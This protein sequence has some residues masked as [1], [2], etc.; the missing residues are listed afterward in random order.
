MMQLSQGRGNAARRRRS[1]AVGLM[2]VLSGGAVELSAS[3]ANAQAATETAKSD[4]AEALFEQA[5]DLV[6]SGKL[7]EACEKFAASN[8]LEPGVG[9]LLYLGDCYERTDRFASAITTFREAGRLA[10]E[11]QD[12]ERAHVAEV[13]SAALQPRAPKL[14]VRVAKKSEVPGLQV[15]LNGTPMPQE[16]WNVAHF[17]DAGAYEVRVAAPGYEPFSSRIELRNGEADLTVV[18]IPRLVETAA[19]SEAGAAA[20]AAVSIEDD[21][22]LVSQETLGLIVGGAGVLLAGTTGLLA[23]FANSSNQDSYDFCDEGDRN[24]CR[25][26]G[27]RLREEAQDFAMVATITG[28]AATAAVAGGVVLY[29]TAP[30][31]E[32]GTPE[33]AVLHVRGHFD[34][35]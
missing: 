5:R 8:A 9:T 1:A 29:L 6:A 11:R 27:V 10:R 28:I 31:L 17:E 33:A 21:A 7:A 25:P 16:G 22:S 19:A 2:W 26:E 34:W 13:R 23:A 12:T 3:A 20:S 32:T 18:K 14:E 24:L 35:F 30:G 15:T 4:A